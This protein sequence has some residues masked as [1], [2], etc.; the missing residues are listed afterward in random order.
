MR[1]FLLV[2]AALFVSNIAFGQSAIVNLDAVLLKKNSGINKGDTVTITDVFMSADGYVVC[3]TESNQRL[4][5]SPAKFKTDLQ[6]V[7]NNIED[8]WRSQIA[9]KTVPATKKIGDQSELRHDMEL[10]ALQFVQVIKDNGLEL[11]DPFLESY[12]Y[13][14]ANKIIPHD[15]LNNSPYNVNVLIQQSP[16]LNAFCYPNGTIVVNT[17]LLAK[18]R[19]EA[20]LVAVLSHEIAHFALDHSVQ[21]VVAAIARQKRAE[22]W[23]AFATGLAAVA[24]GVLAA[25][26]EYYIPGAITASTAIAAAAIA[27]NVVDRLGMKYNH[28]Q[29]IEADQLAKEIL[30]ILG[31][32]PNAL[33]TALKRI[34][35]EL[36]TEGH[37]TAIFLSS[38][39]HPSLA[40]RINRQGVPNGEPEKSYEQM[41][42]F[43]IT[44]SAKIH[45]ENR[46]FKQCITLVEQNITN[47]VATVDDYMLLAQCLIALDNTTETN[48]RILKL[49]DSAKEI[50][51]SN[52]NIYKTEILTYLRLK[53]YNTALTLLDQ[54]KIKIDLLDPSLKH[55]P[56]FAYE[57]NW[58]TNMILKIKAMSI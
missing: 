13:E 39:D 18:L 12:I 22:F 5:Y 43:A 48:A 1:R 56:F 34:A 42:S 14:L 40:S 11:D 57:Y 15:L 9:T 31:Y 46:R 45:F 2:L 23:A 7:V 21:N 3:E 50:D 29:E 25:R 35:T 24:D 38:N 49:I 4:T 55:L 19:S 32:N 37:K 30:E 36:N 41:V 53:D 51:T 26:N 44:N 20:E 33:A 28:E 8:F 54:Y 58:A 27:S 6:F 10:D 17:G 52:I 47:G 16:E